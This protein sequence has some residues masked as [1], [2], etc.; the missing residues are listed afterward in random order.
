M[1]RKTRIHFPDALYHVILRGNAGEEIF[2]HDEDRLYFYTLLAEGV[3]RFG[4]R[5]HAF[6]LMAD[7]VHLAVQVG[8]LPYPG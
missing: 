1:A 7:H 8:E 2:F 5:I 3:E 4:C 6:C